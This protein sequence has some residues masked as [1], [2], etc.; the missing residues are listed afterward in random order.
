MCVFQ[1]SNPAEVYINK[2]TIA[3][4]IST[5]GITRGPAINKSAKGRWEKLP[6]LTD[7]RLI[8]EMNGEF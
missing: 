8:Q 4:H 7:E 5:H 6:P 2:D 1:E 3:I